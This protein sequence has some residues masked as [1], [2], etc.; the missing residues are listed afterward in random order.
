MKWEKKG[1]IFDAETLGLDWFCKNA[2]VPLPYLKNENCLRIF[3]TLCDAQNV[4]RI[5]Y[6]DVEPDNPSNILD[7]SRE[8][9]IDI[10]DDGHFDDNGV[11]TASLFEEGESLYLFYSG[12]QLCVKQPYMIFAGLAVSHDKGD[13]FE[14]ITTDVPLLE[15]VEGEI[16]VRSVPYVIKVDGKY[17]MWYTADAVPAWIKAEKKLLPCYNVKYIESESLLKW[18]GGGHQVLAF[19]NDDEHGIA[20]SRVWIEDGCYKMLYSIRTLSKKYRL[21]YAESKDGIVFTRMDE[22]LGI[23]VSQEGFDSQMLCFGSRIVYK[24]KV[25]LFYSGN[26]YGKGGIGYAQLRAKE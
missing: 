5:G 14:K 9:L 17:R 4:G 22:T 10:G 24:E 26:G 25:Y 21:G 1:K 12:Y 3:A 19:Q 11:V 7:Y 2:M 20:C 16:S 6:V 8:P 18:N 15:R 13:T 23:D